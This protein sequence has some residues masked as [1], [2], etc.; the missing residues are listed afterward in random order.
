MEESTG[1]KFGEL[2]LEFEQKNNLEKQSFVQ[3]ANKWKEIK[4]KCCESNCITTDKPVGDCVKGN[5]FANLINDENIEYIE[6]KM[7][8]RGYSMGKY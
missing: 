1:K 7:N 8:D 6:P 4:E 3:I 5:G 2:N